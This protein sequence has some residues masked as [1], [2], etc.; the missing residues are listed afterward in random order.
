MRLGADSSSSRQQT[1]AEAEAERWNRGCEV[2]GWGLGASCGWQEPKAA[3][4]NAGNDLTEKRS[5]AGLD[6]LPWYVHSSGKE[7]AIVCTR[8]KQAMLFWMCDCCLSFSR[9]RREKKKEKAY[10]MCTY[11]YSSHV[12]ATDHIHFHLA[13]ET[14]RAA[15]LP[16]MST[17]DSR[18]YI[19]PPAQMKKNKAASP[20]KQ[21]IPVAV[22]K[23][24]ELLRLVHPSHIHLRQRNQP[25]TP[26]VMP[27]VAIAPSSIP[28]KLLKASPRR[29]FDHTPQTR[30]QMRAP[31]PLTAPADAGRPC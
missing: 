11:P 13:G 1:A 17:A 21:A 19:L 30:M 10:H 20:P 27:V 7:L 22:A 23:S 24:R 28:G 8:D 4:A 31:F 29:I 26:P 9:V 16:W 15:C 2:T 3:S 18:P 25:S 14:Q 12:F 5:S 6:V